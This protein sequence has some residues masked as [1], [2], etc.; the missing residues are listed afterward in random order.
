[1]CATSVASVDIRWKSAL[2]DGVRSYVMV[3]LV[4]RAGASVSWPSPATLASIR[5]RRGLSPDA[6]NQIGLAVENMKAYEAITTLQPR[7]SRGGRSP[8]RGRETLRAVV[9]GTASMTGSELFYSLVQH[10]ASALRVRTPSSPSVSRGG[11]TGSARAR[12]GRAGA[13]E[14]ISGTTSPAALH[15]SPRGRGRT[16]REGSQRLFPDAVTWSRSARELPGSS[17]PGPLGTADRPPGDPGRPANDG[18]FS[19]ARDLACVC[20]AGGRR[21]GP[22]AG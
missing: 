19:R 3:P 5:R 18:S 2:P 6:A 10:L 17:R 20:G 14:R 15:E 21:A 8:P 11:T 4:A 13:S 12:S 9:E 1:V 16:L 7:G 22:P